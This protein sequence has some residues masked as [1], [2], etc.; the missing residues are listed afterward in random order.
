MWKIKSIARER[1]L[2]ICFIYIA[3]NS[4]SFVKMSQR[5]KINFLQN[6]TTFISINPPWQRFLTIILNSPHSL[7]RNTSF[8]LSDN[9]NNYRWYGQRVKNDSK[10]LLNFNYHVKCCPCV[11]P[12]RFW[13]SGLP[14]GRGEKRCS[15][16]KALR[17]QCKTSIL[18]A[19]FSNDSH[20]TLKSP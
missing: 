11:V 5:Q 9:L 3:R 20:K 1:E 12:W 19:N 13:V 16:K 10:E 8:V 7:T 15:N 17:Q 18:Y 2:F 4:I 14:K 6:K